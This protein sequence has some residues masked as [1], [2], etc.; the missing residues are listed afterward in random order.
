MRIVRNYHLTGPRNKAPSA[1]SRQP[2]YCRNVTMENYLVH[3]SLPHFQMK[4]DPHQ[5]ASAETRRRMV[6]RQIPRSPGF[7][8]SFDGFGTKGSTK[9]CGQ[10]FFFV[11][12]L[13]DPGV[14]AIRLGSYSA[15][16][17]APLRIRQSATASFGRQSMLE[18]TRVCLQWGFEKQ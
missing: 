7:V 4:D 13:L 17:T 2:C 6:M 18:V 14:G 10:I 15:M 12:L 11:I 9:G 3:E 8:F 5:A 16:I 1:E